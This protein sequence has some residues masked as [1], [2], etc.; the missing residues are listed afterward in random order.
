MEV[1]NDYAKTVNRKTTLEYILFQGLNDSI[2]DANALAG[3]ARKLWAKVNIIPYSPV[4]GVKLSAPQK[5]AV[6]KFANRLTECGT[7]T[8]IRASKGKDIKAACGQ[9]AGKKK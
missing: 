4:T 6:E 7:D 1:V 8:T 9:L 3:I 5:I 2:I